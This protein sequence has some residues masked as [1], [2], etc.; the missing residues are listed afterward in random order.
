MVATG[1]GKKPAQRIVLELKEDFSSDSAAPSGAAV[2]ISRADSVNEAASA[3]AVL[4]YTRSEINS[5]LNGIDSAGLKVEEIVKK[6]LIGLM[7]P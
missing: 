5:A 7:K 4:G 6:A 2:G 1:V 3:L